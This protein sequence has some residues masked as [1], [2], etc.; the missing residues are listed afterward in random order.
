VFVA[1]AASGVKDIPDSILHSGGAAAQVA[2]HLEAKRVIAE[3][4]SATAGKA[5]DGQPSEV[6]EVAG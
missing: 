6:A 1:G 2:A 4:Q 3:A 5:A